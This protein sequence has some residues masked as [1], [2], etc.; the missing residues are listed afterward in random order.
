M[1]TAQD[2]TGEFLK[3]AVQFITDN[4][5]ASGIFGPVVLGDKSLSQQV[6]AEVVRQLSEEYPDITFTDRST[7][8]WVY[9][10]F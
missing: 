10:E 3:S 9:F 1:P 5:G 6:G 7:P 2:Y 4:P 8:E